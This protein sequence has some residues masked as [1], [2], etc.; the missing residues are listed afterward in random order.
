MEDEGNVI[1]TVG[2]D[3]TSNELSSL[4]E[5]MLNSRL[6]NCCQRYAE[7]GGGFRDGG[8]QSWTFCTVD[9]VFLCTPTTIEVLPA[10]ESP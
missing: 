5:E 7:K 3:L 2:G 9:W 1:L 8:C 10:M 6:L 4:A